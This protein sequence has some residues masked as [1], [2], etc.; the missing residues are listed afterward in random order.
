MRASHTTSDQFRELHY[1]G[2][3]MDAGGEPNL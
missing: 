2:R 3:F 1:F